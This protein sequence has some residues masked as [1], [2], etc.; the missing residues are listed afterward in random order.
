MKKYLFV[1]LIALGALLVYTNPKKEAHVEAITSVMKRASYKYLTEDS[2]SSVLGYLG[3]LIGMSF[4]DYVLD[5]G[6][7]YHDYV[8]FSR[9]TITLDGE[10]KTVSWGILRQI[11]TFNE[12]ELIKAMKKMEGDDE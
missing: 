12:K 11:R 7:D 4:A 6:L 3:H 2:E 8:F 9:M 10:T 1:L 5:E